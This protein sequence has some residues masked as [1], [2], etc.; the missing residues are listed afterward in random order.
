MLGWVFRILIGNFSFC[1]HEWKVLDNIDVKEK[2]G[3]KILYRKYNLQCEKCGN[4]K[5]TNLN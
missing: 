1:K 3:T 2:Y 5:Q 4:I